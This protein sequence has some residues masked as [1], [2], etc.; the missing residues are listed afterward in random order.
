M[1]VDMQQHQ[2]G[3]A[4]KEPVG[5]QV[6]LMWRRQVNE[7]DLGQRPRAKFAN[8]LGI[9]PVASSTQVE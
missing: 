7:S 5:G 4:G 1:R 3:P 8:C 9:V 6:H 2:I